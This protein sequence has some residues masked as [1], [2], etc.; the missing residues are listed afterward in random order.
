MELVVQCI[1]TSD[2]PQTHH[3]GLLLLGAAAAIFPV[4]LHSLNYSTNIPSSHPH[5]VTTLV[6]SVL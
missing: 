1:R 6:S 3:H 2:M 4:S 5:T